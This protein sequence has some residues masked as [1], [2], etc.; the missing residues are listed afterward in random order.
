MNS[1]ILIGRL[2]NDPEISYTPQQTAVCHFTLAV[3]R[4]KR[5]GEDQGADFLRITVFGKSAENCSR[6]LSKGREAGVRGRISTGSY[7]NRDGVKVYT[8][9]IVADEVKFIGGQSQGSP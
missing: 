3:D 2:A 4:P 7:T 6:Y 5:N 8:T 1:V 9:D